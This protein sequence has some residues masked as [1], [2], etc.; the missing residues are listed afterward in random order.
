MKKSKKFAN[1]TAI[2]EA[3]EYWI[4]EQICFSLEKEG[5]KR[6]EIDYPNW[7]KVKT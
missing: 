2:K 1:I 7:M 3:Q 4:W 6:K 5:F